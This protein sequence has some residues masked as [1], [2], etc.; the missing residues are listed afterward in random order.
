[1]VQIIYVKMG[2]PEPSKEDCVLVESMLG[3]T[4]V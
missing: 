4:T 1:M 2:T 3:G